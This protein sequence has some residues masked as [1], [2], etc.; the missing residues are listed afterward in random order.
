[1]VSTVG[2]A[3]AILRCA[4]RF[5]G[6][7]LALSLHSVRQ[8]V[9]ERLIPLA[10]KYPLDQLR[11]TI[12]QLNGRFG[13]KVMI[14]YLMLSGVN[15][16]PNDAREL[17]AWL[18]GLNVHVNLIP[19]NPI[20]DAPHLAAS[21]RP[22]REA[23]AAALKESGLKTTIRHSLGNDIAAACGQLVRHENRR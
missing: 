19:F 21:D 5:P 1:M 14:E 17:I 6:V 3:D 23:F 9:R 13:A 11:D 2:V 7:N 18:D 15:D 22:T 12:L 8:T 20:D 10:K 4:E 16:S